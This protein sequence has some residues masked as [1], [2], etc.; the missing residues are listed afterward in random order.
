MLISS[1]FTD[2]YSQQDVNGWYWLNAKP[3]GNN[4]NWV[5]ITQTGSHYALGNKG[6]FAQSTDG[7]MQWSIN[8]RVGLFDVSLAYTGI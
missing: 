6:T 8:S 2:S 5:F 4:L 7:G 1:V 3:T